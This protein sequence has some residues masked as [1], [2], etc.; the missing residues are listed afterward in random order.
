MSAFELLFIT[1][2]LGMFLGVAIGILI[3]TV[4]KAEKKEMEEENV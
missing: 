2:I 4:D 1:G 3:K